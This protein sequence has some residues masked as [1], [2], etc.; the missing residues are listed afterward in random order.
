MI[1]WDEHKKQKDFVLSQ[2]K[3]L[4]QLVK[5]DISCPQ[6]GEELYK[7]VGV[8][9]ASHPPKYNYKCLKCGWSSAYY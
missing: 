5:T 3:L 9:L 2:S 6:C 8:V 1:T 4:E 7:D